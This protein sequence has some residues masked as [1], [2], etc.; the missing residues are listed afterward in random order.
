[1]QKLKSII[2]RSAEEK[3]HDHD[4]RGLGYGS[5]AMLAPFSCLTIRCYKQIEN[6]LPIVS[7]FGL[8]SNKSR[9]KNIY[10]L[11]HSVKEGM[12]KEACIYLFVAAIKIGLSFPEIAAMITLVSPFKQYLVEERHSEVYIN[13]LINMQHLKDRHLFL[14]DG[15]LLFLRHAEFDL[16]YVEKNY[17]NSSNM[18]IIKQNLTKEKIV[19]KD[20]ILVGA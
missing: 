12:H 15:I 9:Q 10:H 19:V 18:F 2:E 16:N 13:K 14:E 6:L 11:T 8:Q 4:L 3:K 17:I 20:K 7:C 1:M 5:S